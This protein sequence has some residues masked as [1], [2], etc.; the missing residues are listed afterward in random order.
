MVGRVGVRVAAG[1][2]ADARVEADEEADQI[3]G[4]GVREKVGHVRVFAWRGVAS[5]TLRF[6]EGGGSGR[7]GF[8]DWRWRR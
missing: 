5:G 6:V 8:L 7:S 2:G 1:G 4:D 3:G